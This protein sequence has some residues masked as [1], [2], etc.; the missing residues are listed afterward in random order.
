M[1]CISF[2]PPDELDISG[3]EQDLKAVFAQLNT[4]ANGEETEVFIVA[5]KNTNPA[6]Y[7]EALNALIGRVT[8]GPTKVSVFDKN[9][10]VIGSQASF[11]GF[12]SF[13]SFDEGAAQGAHNHHEYYEG[14]PYVHPQSVPLIVSVRSAK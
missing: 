6:P 4:L 11:V 9:I 1:I 7:D 3:T 12:A 5:D 2:T 10:E 8:T 14:N 13:F